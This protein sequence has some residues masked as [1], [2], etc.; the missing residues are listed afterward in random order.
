[1]SINRSLSDLIA[2]SFD[3]G[4][5]RRGIAD[6]DRDEAKQATSAKALGNTAWSK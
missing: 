6:P 1:M 4:G 2:R 5:F 3:D